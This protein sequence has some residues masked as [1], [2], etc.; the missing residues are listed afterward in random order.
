MNGYIAVGE[1]VR[2]FAHSHGGNVTALASSLFA[3]PVDLVVTMGTPVLDGYQFAMN[4]VRRGIALSSENDPVQTSGGTAMLGLFE[5]AGRE[6]TEPG[7]QNILASGFADHSSY[8]QDPGLTATLI[9]LA[10]TPQAQ[11]G[12]GTQTLKDFASPLLP[13]RSK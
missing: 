2:I 9:D 10:L 6:R 4:N 13:V 8:W 1:P 7:F 11:V 12:A 3:G 5:A